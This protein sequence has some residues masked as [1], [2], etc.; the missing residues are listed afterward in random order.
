MRCGS[1]RALARLAPRLAPRLALWAL[2]LASGLKMSAIAGMVAPYPTMSEIS[3]RAAGTY[4]SPRLFDN[5]NV[6]R[7]VRAV[8]KF[9]P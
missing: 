9:V 3:K 6:K 4:F 8:Q 5:P 7:F 1:L 2:A